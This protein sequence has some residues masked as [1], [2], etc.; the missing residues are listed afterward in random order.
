M[1]YLLKL[2]FDFEYAPL[3]LSVYPGVCGHLFAQTE[4][5]GT[6]AVSAEVLTLYGLGEGGL[7][8]PALFECIAQV[9]KLS[10]AVGELLLYGG[11]VAGLRGETA[12]CGAGVEEYVYSS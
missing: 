7:G 8:C 10:A 4:I 2:P 9:I 1:P 12:G 5:L 3:L 11:Y 6:E